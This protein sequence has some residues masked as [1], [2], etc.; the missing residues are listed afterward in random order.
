MREGVALLCYINIIKTCR[1]QFRSV[2]IIY[3]NIILSLSIRRISDGTCLRV[4]S[5]SLS[6][7]IPKKNP[8]EV[9]LFGAVYNC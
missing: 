8:R 3:V 2:R 5:F 7:F 4:P 6:R 1:Y 9:A